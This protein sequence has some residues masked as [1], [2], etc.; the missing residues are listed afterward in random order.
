MLIEYKSHKIFAF[1]DTLGLNYRLQ[2]PKDADILICVGDCTKQI[3]RNDY[4]D[5]EFQKFL[6]WFSRQPAQLKIYV[7]S[8]NDVMYMVNPEAALLLV[9]HCITV[10]ENEGIEFEGISFY[11]R[12]NRSQ[13]FRE[14]VNDVPFGVDFLITHVPAEDSLYK[15]IGDRKLKVIIKEVKPKF[16]LFGH[17][18]GEGVNMKTIGTTTYC[19]VSAFNQITYHHTP[20]DAKS[21]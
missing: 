12:I 13:S 7:P 20:M 14:D 19:N 5:V 9:P 16:H 15:G 17:I 10:L 8:D 18:Y 3:G 21:E 2:I 4:V 6:G 1:A 11:S